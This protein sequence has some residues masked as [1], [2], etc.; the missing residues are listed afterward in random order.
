[1]KIEFYKTQKVPT[2][3]RLLVDDKYLVDYEKTGLYALPGEFA[4]KFSFCSEAKTCYDKILDAIIR[5][6]MEQSYDHGCSWRE[7]KRIITNPDRKS[8]SSF[9]VVVCFRVRDGG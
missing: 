6:M 5:T 7:T 9:D 8:C 1:M 4:W 2:R 3:L